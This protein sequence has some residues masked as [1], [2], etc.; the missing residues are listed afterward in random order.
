M[1]GRFAIVSGQN[2][3]TLIARLAATGLHQSS[4]G[5]AEVFADA[6]MVVAADPRGPGI[7][8]GTLFDRRDGRRVIKL[9]TG[10]FHAIA[11]S[12]GRHLIDNFWGAYIAVSG[13]SGRFGTSIVRDPSA[14]IQLFG[15][16][17]GDCVLYF[18]DFAFALEIAQQMPSVD[19]AAAAHRLRFPSLR[20][21]ETGLEDIFEVIPGSRICAQTGESEQLWR[22]WTFAR[23]EPPPT[24][25]K[26]EATLIG[27]V[28][29]WASRYAQIEAELSGGLDSSVVAASMATTHSTWRAVTYATDSVEGDE[30]SYARAVARAVGVDLEEHVITANSLDCMEVSKYP[31]VRPGGF[32]V[33]AAIDRLLS[34]SSRASGADAIF[35]GGG[36]DN[37]FCK[38]R[39]AGPVVDAFTIEGFQSAWR[40]ARDLADLC[41]TNLWDSARHSIRQWRRRGKT[42]WRASDNLLGKASLIECRG[43]P[44]FEGG[45]PLP[46]KR[47]HIANLVGVLP[48]LDGYDRTYEFPVIYPL[49]SQPVVE[50]CLAVPSW[51]WIAG[52][53]DR[54][55]ARDAF[56]VRL[57]PSVIQRRSKGGLRSVMIPAFERSRAALGS[58]LC[59]GQLA[60]KGL[61]DR[62]AIKAVLAAP[63]SAAR[64][65]YVRIFELADV[66]LWVRSI[67]ALGGGLHR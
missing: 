13:T 44:W 2:C 50:L 15:W 62:D 9:S 18:N 22:P 24:P 48:F 32:G 67:D 40:V 38:I 10:H 8:L 19:W 23:S 3:E 17:L 6:N 41:E 47:A 1:N 33:L 20:I 7:V 54:A 45:S 51:Q 65:D 66:E 25:E 60:E 11:D 30:R 4:I 5:S 64:T 58:L 46:G 34:D 35:S 16:S 56:A 37:I 53:R 36:G 52:G 21:A 27:C 55:F 12:G 43:H 28:N 57:P 39:T 61:I 42:I 59:D 63:V 49:L 26:L 31:R 14:Q 29:S